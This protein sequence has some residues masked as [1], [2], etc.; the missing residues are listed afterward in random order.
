MSWNPANTGNFSGNWRA[1]AHF[2][3]QSLTT[4]DP[5]QTASAGFDSKFS[6]FQQ[7]FAAGF[8]FQNDET[9]TGGLSYS[10][11]Y[12]SLGYHRTLSENSFWLGAQVGYVF[13]SVNDWN[14][15]DYT[16]GGFTAPSGETNFGESINYA[17]VNLGLSWKRKIGIFEPEAAFALKH[18]NK[19]NISFFEGDQQED[20]HTIVHLSS[21]IKINESFGV[22][23]SFLFETQN[24]IQPTLFGFYSTYKL[25]G[26]TTPI[27]R[28]YLGMYL[29]NGLTSQLNAFSFMA[30]TRIKMIDLVVSYDLNMG[31]FNESAGAT[32]AF[33]IALIYRKMPLVLNSYSIPC[34]RY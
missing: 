9:G 26:S 11:I 8:L 18:I 22:K 30:G 13:A 25:I 10:N 16:T 6:F 23:P 4:G 15:W 28:V 34:E 27:K 19:P 32:G 20:I 7:N 3:N 33:E 2:R 5:F 24:N 31:D 12:A 17:D 21:G 14:T 29:R 1:M